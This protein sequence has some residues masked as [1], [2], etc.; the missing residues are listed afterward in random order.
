M[1]DC[2]ADPPLLAA[3]CC[4]ACNATGQLYERVTRR[5]NACLVVSAL[6]W[7]LFLVAQILAQTSNALNRTMWVYVCEEEECAWVVDWGAV[8]TSAVL[9]G[10]AGL[11]G[12]LSTLLS[13]YFLCVSRQMVRQRD[14]IP[15]GCC[16]SC[17]DCCVSY[18]CSCC[19]LIQM[20]KQEK[21]SGPA[22]R[23]CTTTGV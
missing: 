10:L 5:A 7:S 14:Q 18:W 3:G 21:V 23:A 19:A 9:G 20:F 12:F 11:V 8:R 2:C 15:E 6:G 16:G 13:T 1:C 4:C 22:Y 17:D